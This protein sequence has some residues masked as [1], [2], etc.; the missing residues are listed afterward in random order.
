MCANTQHLDEDIRTSL[1]QSTLL[2][3]IDN[4]PTTSIDLRITLK[5]TTVR[6]PSS[7]ILH[8]STLRTTHPKDQISKLFFI[9]F[10]TKALAMRLNY[11]AKYENGTVATYTSKDAGRITDAVG[12][13]IFANIQTWSGGKYTA[14]RREEHSVIT[15]KNVLPA[16]NKGIGSDQV[17][18]M[19][20]IVNKNI[21]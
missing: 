9:L 5:S 2:K 10:A 18:E 7:L 11:S 14:T 13:K 17:K 21:K 20:S 8:Q 6:N 16:M 1:N 15:V 4:I 3:L 19:Q 12:D